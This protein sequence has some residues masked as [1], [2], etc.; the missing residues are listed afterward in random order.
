MYIISTLKANIMYTRVYNVRI[1]PLDV[2]EFSNIFIN[3]RPVNL[4]RIVT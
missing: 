1:G 3:I 2:P 4:T